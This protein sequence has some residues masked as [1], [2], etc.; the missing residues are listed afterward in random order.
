MNDN[1]EQILEEF[2]LKFGILSSSINLNQVK[3]AY[4]NLEDS[5]EKIIEWVSQNAQ[6]PEESATYFLQFG[7]YEDTLWYDY[8]KDELVG[9]IPTFDP[10]LS[11]DELYDLFDEHISYFMRYGCINS[12]HILSWDT[13]YVLIE[14]ELDNLIKVKRP[15]VLLSGDVDDINEETE[16]DRRKREDG[17]C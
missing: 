8:D 5:R 7:K 12:N 13:K 3:N 2:G 16:E 9:G 17:Y 4:E 14:D 6:T 1:F 11:I 10:N 15:D